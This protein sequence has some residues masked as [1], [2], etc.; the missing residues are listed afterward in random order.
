V[1]IRS[2]NIV[3][4]YFKKDNGKSKILVKVNPVHMTGLELIVYPKGRLESRDLD[5][6]PSLIDDLQAEGFEEVS[7][8]EFNLLL[9][10]L[11]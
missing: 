3:H 10:G 4:Q 7:G 9:S 6:D 1:A 11:V 5:V 8:M 2:S